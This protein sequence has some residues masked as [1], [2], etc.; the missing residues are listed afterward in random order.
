MRIAYVSL[1]WARTK[2]SGVGKKIQS[3]LEMWR[4]RGH[5]ARVFMHAS[6][7]EP[8]ERLIEADVYPYEARGKL[9]TEFNRIRA[10]SRMVD[11][12]AAFKPDVIYLRYGIY[13]FPAHRLMAIA[14]VIE[15]IN[16][17]DLTQHEDLGGLYSLYNRL[18]RG[19][20]L[21]FVRGLVTVSRELEV[22]RAFAVYRKPTRVIANGIELDSFAPLPAPSNQT[23]RL[24]FIGSPGY[25]WHGVDKLVD[26]ARRFSDVQLDIVGYDSLPEFEPLPPNLTLHG[27][28]SSDEYLK[29][30]ARADAAISSLALHRI[31]LNEASTL[32]SRECLALGLPL[33]V[34][35]EDTDLGEAGFD[36]LLK[37]PNKEDN[38]Q[39]HGETI[40][41]FAY[42]MRG[43]R[44]NR[45]ALKDRIDSGRKEEL[46]LKFFEEIL[47][48]TNAKHA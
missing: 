32:K 17:N 10:A 41:E 7:G 2:D 6:T 43:V 22:S 37:I 23:P 13:V 42:R 44:A 18:T 24:V 4:A 9:V 16:T 21:R 12:V 35:Y 33:V 1:H 34:A 19:I 20:F 25:L 40:H 30:L 8:A 45:A 48:E 5:K 46:R 11:A 26:F 38:I 36:F 28:L 29:V 14:P 3:Q 39:T 15:E 47:R 27:Y 31:Q